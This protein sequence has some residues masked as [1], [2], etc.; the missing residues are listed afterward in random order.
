MT[1]TPPD[2]RWWIAA[3]IVGASIDAAMIWIALELFK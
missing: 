2:V 3:L 1:D